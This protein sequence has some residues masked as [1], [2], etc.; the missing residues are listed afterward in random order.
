[1][2]FGRRGV[3]TA[4]LTVLLLTMGCAGWLHA[5]ENTGKIE[6]RVSDVQQLAVAHA[7]V[8]LKSSQGAGVRQIVSDGTGHYELSDVPAGTYTLAVS[9]G[10]FEVSEQM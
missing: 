8:E 3:V 9:S 7:G 2:I 10:G 5:Q 6:G 4:R 1:M